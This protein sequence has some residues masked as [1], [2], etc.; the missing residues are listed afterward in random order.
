VTR[1]VADLI[2]DPRSIVVYGASSDPDKLSGRPLDYLKRFGYGGKLYA[3]NPRR[4]SVQDIPSHASISDVPGPIDLAIIVVPAEAVPEAVEACAEAGVG[5][6]TVFA[7]GF[8]EAQDPVSRDAQTRIGTAARRSGMR[9][10]GPNCLGSFSLRQRAFATFSTAFDVPEALPDSPIAL[11]SQSGAVGTFTYSTMTGTGLGVR[12]FA[13]TGNEVDISVVEVLSALVERDDVHLL[14]GHLEGFADP[15]ALTLLADR[16]DVLGKPLLLLKAGRTP[17]GER[18]IG[19]HTGSRAG[20]DA[21]FQR[22]LDEHGAVRARSMEEMCD[23]ALGFVSGRRATGPR[24]TIV[25][26][27][28]G[29]GALASDVAVDSGLEVE[30]WA[31]STQ[32][33]IADFLP[34]FASTANPIDLTGALIND[35][36]IL[37]RTLETACASDETDVVLVVLGNSDRAARELVDTCVRNFQATHKPFFVVWTGGSGQPRRD[38]LAAGVPTYTEP[39]RAVQAIARLVTFSQRAA[40]VP[41]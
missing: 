35:S 17:V 36:S 38:L 40:D 26:Q 22:I 1:S 27:S 15:R 7:S 31:T 25:T 2:F 12:Y 39:V 30:P 3:V 24:L 8:A 10:L 18:A 4:E 34:Y 19:A 33:V 20:D 23:L 14:M 6:A 37:D 16:A 9:I 28:G 11:A 5:V 21:E 13:N 32:R 41:A 29:A